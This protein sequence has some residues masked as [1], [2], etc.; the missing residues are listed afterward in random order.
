MNS[1]YCFFSCSLSLSLSL[2][3][4]RAL[5]LIHLI[6]AFA[7]FHRFFVTPFL[8]RC[9]RLVQTMMRVG[10]GGS[11][12]AHAASQNADVKVA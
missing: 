11:V 4:P 3:L 12:D 10:H 1:L 2:F 7:G 6:L 9:C 5:S 8:R